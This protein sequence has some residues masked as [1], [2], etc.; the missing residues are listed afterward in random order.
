MQVIDSKAPAT[1]T[2]NTAPVLCDA[3]AAQPKKLQQMVADAIALRKRLAFREALSHA[4][5][6]R[7]F[8]SPCSSA[9]SSGL[10]LACTQTSTGTRPAS[11]LRWRSWAL[12][13]GAVRSLGLVV[14]G[15]LQRL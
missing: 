2:P 11:R 10:R 15:F 12:R 6:G 8:S 4:A 13:V 14:I 1:V 5:S 7:G 3:P 9:S